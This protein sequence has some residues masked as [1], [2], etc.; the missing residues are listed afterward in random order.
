MRL[1]HGQLPSAEKQQA[2]AA[3]VAGEAQVLVSTTV[4][5]VGVDVANATVMVIEGAR[6]FGLSQLHQLR[7]RV[8]RGAEESYCL[9]LADQADP[10]VF[11]R[12]RLFERTQ[13]GF[14]L[15]EADLRARGEGQLFGERQSGWGDLRVARLLT[16]G[17]LL[18]EARGVAQEVLAE[19]PSLR[20]PRYRLLGEAV[21]AR[22]GEQVHWLDRA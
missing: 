9:L 20:Q 2:M 5:E 8:G 16:D 12:L 14:R 15:A 3:F 18:E 22:F 13:D 21:Q 4:I 11:D 6:R 1:L 19:D 10:A 17:R 7:G